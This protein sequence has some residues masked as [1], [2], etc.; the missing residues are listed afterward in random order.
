MDAKRRSKKKI[1]LSWHFFATSH[2][3]GVADGIGGSIKRLVY[4]SIL[5][6]QICTSATDFINIGRSKT[7]NIELYVI[8]Q[9]QIDNAKKQLE[10]IFQSL[11]SITETKKI[12]CVNVL[13]NNS[14]EHKYY[15]NSSTKKIHRFE[16]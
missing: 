15:S 2:S 16:V 10:T 11:K 7:N 8:N 1:Q 12:H 4:R 3:K 6:G 9:Y 5:S 13:A 14:I